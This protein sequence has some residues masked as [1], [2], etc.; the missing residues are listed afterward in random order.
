MGLTGV[1]DHYISV[2][3]SQLFARSWNG[4][5]EAAPIL[6]LH[7][8]LGCIEVWRDFPELLCQAT[9]RS[10]I[11]YD[12][13]GFGQSDPNPHTL[14]DGH[15][16]LES[17]YVREV[18]DQLGIA[19]CIPFGHSIGGEMAVACG[20]RLP[21]RCAAVIAMSAQSWLEEITLDAI[22]AGAA[23]F[24]DPEQFARLAKYHGDKAQ[25]VLDAWVETW[26]R[27]SMR[28]WTITPELPQVRCPLLV[29]H[30]ENDGFTS[31][32]QPRTMAQLA[33]GP[34]R[35]EIIP[36]CGHLPHRERPETVLAVVSD[37][38]SRTI[39]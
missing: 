20:S 31:L 16:E 7:D 9:G 36:G 5:S 14:G 32:E 33:G 28:G 2:A 30:G 3:D 26:L 13:L 19:R 37:F 6:L 1:T 4:T 39:P 22:R 8:S 34:S 21:D 25:W 18:L 17:N 15:V 24:R 27:P 35:L 10:V 38:L 11:A 23:Q 12:R 29:I